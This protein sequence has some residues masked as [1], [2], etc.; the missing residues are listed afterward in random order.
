MKKVIL[1]LVAACLLTTATP[2][3]MKAGNLHTLELREN[4]CI[5]F[6]CCGGMFGMLFGYRNYSGHREFGFYDTDANWH[7]IW[8]EGYAC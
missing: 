5:S 7:C 2:L 4:Y 1:L 6:D 3:Q 8:L